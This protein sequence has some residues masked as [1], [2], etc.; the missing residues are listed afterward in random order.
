MARKKSQND[1]LLQ[2]EQHQM[3]D[4]DQLI[5]KVFVPAKNK[6]RFS[7][8]ALRNVGKKVSNIG[9]SMGILDEQSDTESI[10]DFNLVSS[11]LTYVDEAGIPRSDSE[12]A[13]TH[14]SLFDPILPNKPSAQP[15][16][17]HN[18]NM[19]GLSQDRSIHNNINQVGNSIMAQKKSSGSGPDTRRIHFDGDQYMNSPYVPSQP[20][21]YPLSTNNSPYIHQQSYQ[22]QPQQYPVAGFIHQ[23]YAATGPSSASMNN[24]GWNTYIDPYGDQEIEQMRRKQIEETWKIE[25]QLRI[26]REQQE[27]LNRATSQLDPA[28]ATSYPPQQIRTSN[29]RNRSTDTLVDPVAGL[30]K[31]I[32]SPN[33]DK[34]VKEIPSPLPNENYSK[35]SARAVIDKLRGK[36]SAPSPA[37]SRAPRVSTPKVTAPPR[38]MSPRIVELNDDDDVPSSSSTAVVPHSGAGAVAAGAGLGAIAASAPMA[39]V[40]AINAR[41][42]VYN[43]W[44]NWAASWLPGPIDPSQQQSSSEAGYSVRTPGSMLV[45]EDP[46]AAVVP[47]TVD[48]HQDLS[49]PEDD[50]YAVRNLV[51][52]VY[53][54]DADSDGAR[55]ESPTLSQQWNF[56]K[57]LQFIKPK[58]TSGSSAS[59]VALFNRSRR[60]KKSPKG[61]QVAAATG[62]SSSATSSSPSAPKAAGAVVA[63]PGVKDASKAGGPG[64][65][66]PADTYSR[67][68]NGL[69]QM[70]YIGLIL[71]PIDAIRGQSNKLQIFVVLVELGIVIWLMYLLSVVVNSITMVIKAL[72]VPFFIFAKLVGSY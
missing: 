70:P 34:N 16:L 64:S 57:G 11:P 19:H 24:S 39:L 9:T 54:V 51:E 18:H 13:I 50:K 67:M 30:D 41:S 22:Y 53:E 27:R 65:G 60:K 15:Q 31:Y 7:N 38:S 42:T 21:M 72:F 35:F 36:K 63:D 46:M 43:D 12:F 8:K 59:G 68:A 26:I 3:S 17:N 20:Q 33:A 44:K 4:V 71:K 6:K 61:K 47:A 14:D 52:H 62:V 58:S 1:L 23:P 66:A 2:N 40:R 5:S 25:E 28:L 10:Q 49:S 48:P 37:L 32:V 29:D 69:R 55:A 56:K 45:D